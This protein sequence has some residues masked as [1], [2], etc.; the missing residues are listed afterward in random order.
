[1]TAGWSSPTPA[2]PRN[3]RV[4]RRA[5]SVPLRSTATRPGET[6]E[7]GLPVRYPWAEDYRG[8]A[9]VVYGHTPVPEAIWVNK[10]ICIDTGCVFGGRLTALRY[11][12]RELVSVPAHE[13][14]YE[15]ARPLVPPGGALDDER[16]A[17]DLDLEDVIGKRIIETRLARTVTIREDNAV[18][19][20][21]VMSR[22][23]VDPRWLAYL[24]PTMSP[25]ATTDREG[26]LEH[27]VEAFSAYRDGGVEQVVCEE[28]HMG[29][30][31]VV[32]VCRDPA[33]AAGA[34]RHRISSG[35]HHLHPHRT[36]V[37]HRGRAR[38]GIS[39]KDPRRAHHRRSV[40]RTLH[41]LAGPRLR[42][43]ALVGEG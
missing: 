7:Y 31:A 22:F 17:D 43:S 29:S 40:G 26:L 38:D 1:M 34:L 20:L 10:T 21:E 23:A 4:G 33:V 27:P 9:F 35:R 39:R 6:D 37:L 8:Q 41:R 13:V 15:P 32:V 18:A 28:K 12:E 42:A 19:A 36:A 25:T 3:C 2:Y 24:P 11:P 5:R 14:Y 30:R 16:A